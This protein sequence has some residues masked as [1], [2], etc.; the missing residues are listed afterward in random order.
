MNSQSPYLG[1]KMRIERFYALGGGCIDIS[2]HKKN[3]YEMLV[4]KSGSTTSTS[5]LFFLLK[6]QI[7]DEKMEEWVTNPWIVGNGFYDTGHKYFVSANSMWNISMTITPND[8]DFPTGD[9][10]TNPDLLLPLRDIQSIYTAV[11]ASPVGAF[12]S[13]DCHPL[14]RLRPCLSSPGGCYGGSYNFFDPD[15]FLSISAL[16]IPDD[17]YLYEEVKKVIETSGKFICIIDI[18][19]VCKKGQIPHHLV[20]SCKG[21]GSC[22]CFENI[23][24]TYAALSGAVQT[25]PNM[26][27]ILS[28]IKYAE[29]S[30]SYD[31]LKNMQKTIEDAFNFLMSF[32]NESYGMMY[33]PGPLWI[34]TFNRSGFTTDTNSA[35]MHLLKKM[36]EFERFFKNEEKAVF[37][38]S[39]RSQIISSMN[40]HL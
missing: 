4:L 40:L 2:F 15:S 9:I 32:F 7:Q 3:D 31:W 23:C 1:T 18:P 14:G 8:L 37:Y 30:G 12:A 16:V 13:H 27:W 38:E 19:G 36:S 25:G 22:K 34:D 28:V 33:S 5:G 24:V 17:K 20:D 10:P 6:G 29:F 21:I 11:Y 35:M 26:F 39:I